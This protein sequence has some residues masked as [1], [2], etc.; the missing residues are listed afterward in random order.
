MVF[1]SQ[2]AT[3]TAI[4]KNI[5]FRTPT[6]V[7]R[8]CH[9]GHIIVDSYTAKKVTSLDYQCILNMWTWANT[10]AISSDSFLHVK[11]LKAEFFTH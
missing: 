9:F 5:F 3:A 10:K 7:S 11:I 6:N 8:W 2:Q 4:E 1:K